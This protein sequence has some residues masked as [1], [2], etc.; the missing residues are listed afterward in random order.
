MDKISGVQSDTEYIMS[1]GKIIIG[2]EGTIVPM[3]HYDE[4]GE[5][6]GFD[7][8]YAKEVCS[9]IGIDPE[10]KVIDWDKKE[11]LLDNK[12]IDCVWS[13]LTITK[14]RM[15]KMSFS[16]VYLN[17]SQIVLIRKADA[18]KYTNLDS[19]LSAKFFIGAGS[20]GENII[21]SN[22]KLSSIQ[23]ETS[24][25]VQLMINNVKLGKCDAIIV[26]YTVAKTTIAKKEYSDL[27]IV[28]G[29]NLENEEYGVGFRLDSDMIY[30]VNNITMDMMTDG[31][32]DNIA[33]KYDLTELYEPAI[34]TD[35]KYIKGKRQLIIGIANNEPPMTY[36]SN[37]HELIGFDIDFAK[38]VS[39]NLGLNPL[40]KN[41]D[42]NNKEK[43]LK[44][45]KI[46]CIWSSL[47]V[48]EQ[49]RKNMKFSR[50]YMSNK[51]CIV[52]RKSD[53]T[54][55]KSWD[56]FPYSSV[57][58]TAGIDTTGE[59]A[60]HNNPYLSLAN[61]IPSPTMDESLDELQ[62]GNCDVA[63]IDYI[64]ATAS[65]KGNEYSDLMI[66]P[67]LDLANEFYAIGFRANSDMTELVNEAIKELIKDNT[68]L[69][70]AKKYE[71]TELY[72]SVE[73]QLEKSDSTYIMGNG[74]IIIGVKE[75]N[76]PFSYL[77]KGV[78]T[79]IDI[80]LSKLF[81]VLGID[82]K[83]KI[84]NDWSNKEENLNSKEI[85]CI[86]NG[87]MNVNERK[88]D[89]R[90]N[91]FTL[92]E[93]QAVIIDRS[94]GS[95]FPNLE[96]LSGS[97]IAAEKDST[98]VKA[99]KTNT[100][101]KKA[102]LTEVD[103]QNNMLDLL[104]KGTY[105]AVIMDY[106]NAKNSIKNY[107]NLI[108]LD[109][110]N[111]TDM[112]YAFSFR[113]GSDMVK[114][115]NSML[116]KL[117]SDGTIR[118]IINS[119]DYHV[120][121]TDLLDYSDLINVMGSGKII[122]GIHKNIPPMS[123]TNEKG[124]L[125]GFD[126]EFAKEVCSRL[127]I[128]P[129]FH[130]I[131]WEDMN[132]ELSSKNIDCVWSSLTVTDKR[133]E[134]MKFSRV[135]LNNRQIIIIHKSNAEVYKDVSSFSKRILTALNGSSGEQSI[136]HN[137]YLSS[138]KYILSNSIEEALNAIKRKSFDG[139]V[140]DY[141][142]ARSVVG[143]GD[144]ADLMI[145]SNVNLGD[146]E[147]AIGFRSGSDL[148]KK[149]N[150][151]I[152]DLDNEKW[153]DNIASKYELTDLLVNNK[154]SDSSYIMGNGK[155]IIGIEGNIVPMTYY[156]EYGELTGFDYEFAKEACSRIG[157][158]V[159]FRII[160]WEKKENELNNYS[161]DCV[162]SSL[163]ITE[164]RLKKMN[165]SYVY[166]TN[167]Q[168]VVI[169][170][171]DASKYTTLESL[172]S[173][174]FSVEAGAIGEDIIKSN[175]YISKASYEISNSVQQI[176]EDLKQEKCDA[177]IIDYT[178]AKSTIAKKEFKDL[179]IIDGINL[180]NEEYGVGFRFDSD[181]PNKVNSVIMDMMLDGTLENIAKKYD[182]TDLY[183]PIIKTDSIYLMEKK[184]LII[185]VVDNRPTMTYYNNTDELIGFDIDFAKAVTQKLGL[186]PIFKNI[187][188]NN[189][190]S[191]LKTRKVDCIWSAVSVTEQRRK[192]M[193]FSRVYM[194][195]KQCVV[196][197]KSDESKFKHLDD[198]AYTSVR[199]TAGIDTTG[200]EAIHNNPYLSLSRYI[201]SPTEEESL[202]ELK[203]GNCDAA[204]ID[205][206]MALPSIKSSEYSDLMIVPGLDLPNEFYAIGFRI[207]SDMT[208]KVNEVIKELIKDKTLLNLAKKYELTEL[209][210]SVK[211]Q[212]E[213]SDSTYIMG[214]GEIIIGVK[215]NNKP[216]S[217]LEKGVLTG[218]DIEFSKMFGVLGI[219]V[220]HKIIND[221]SNKNEKLKSKEIDCIWNGVMNASERSK[222]VRY[223][224]VVLNEKQVVIIDRSNGS[225]FP[226][227]ES[228]SGSKIAAEKDSAG[229]KVIKANDY[230]KKA[231]LT[232][233]DSQSNLVD[234]LKKGTYDAI[235]M[236]YIKAKKNIKY[237]EDVII[238]EIIDMIDTQYAF[239]FRQGSDMVK[240]FN[241][242]LM[243]LTMDGMI[244]DIIN[245]YDQQFSFAN[246]MDYSDLYNIIGNR[247]LVIGIHNNI[248]PLSYTNEKGELVGFDT[249][250][251]KEVCSRLGIEPE[252]YKINWE[253]MF[254]ELSSRNVDC[255]WSSLTVTDKRR[256][257]M[258]FSRVYL[259][260]KQ[261]VVIHK[262]NVGIYKD[263][264]TLSKAKIT[265][266]NGSS[267]EQA[268]GI[269][270]YLS[271]AK[272]ILSNTV[273]E[274]L[275]A[276]KEKGIDAFI[277]D[278]T[279]ARS[280][281]GK[282]DYVDLVIIDNVNLGNEEFA[283]GFRS[284]SDLTIKINEII[285][286]LIDE[287][288][289]DKIAEKYELT[290][291]LKRNEIDNDTIED[292]G[293][294][295]QNNGAASLKNI[296]IFGFVNIIAAIL[297][298][299]LLY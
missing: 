82:V 42:W 160:D 2:I 11:K 101:L 229:V 255:I 202:I 199:I 278:Y 111:V 66:I 55:F 171:K 221:W 192:N 216:F 280:V 168:I 139:F 266:L 133:R 156:N 253:D 297:A 177:I 254:N 94:N 147:F 122:I 190:E 27:M 299:V 93:K 99:I 207:N 32:L 9:R 282:G 169:K 29:I 87:I 246:I 248:P 23:Y 157:V 81:R 250:F 281:V 110:I 174:K 44:S 12:T 46:D 162:W 249:E 118:N 43:E 155:M 41:I 4:Y 105:D 241:P 277:I 134:N 233:V 115:V 146:E 24:D 291:L 56:D 273:E 172:K 113:Q 187:D 106:T 152:R 170:K 166:L 65:V 150:E 191:D 231:T 183:K 6:T 165:F 218:I 120:G 186:T 193:K 17:N 245:E 21:K 230:L 214:N 112:Q 85:D 7:Y 49:R 143:K 276:V 37:T 164:E 36:Y 72:E 163:T 203:K 284:G 102:T 262:S 16:Y 57:R 228:L 154:K 45:R 73:K 288:W 247:K 263:A 224:S 272:Y 226:N 188:W 131:N 200:E 100:Y 30:K 63:I 80:E 95:K 211:K 137:P 237:L 136:K 74:E 109:E 295:N 159:E 256:E 151:V 104:K 117:I 251:A 8:E 153:L 222:D 91:S 240:K 296:N 268:I 298:I 283:I 130:K 34:V 144:Y 19:L 3:V 135:Y 13:A 52:I 20:V 238:L 294:K 194:T 274:A 217:Y 70:L 234:L 223:N 264:T 293:L 167:K 47:T 176:F 83:H 124:E 60:I 225:K 35:K 97:K 1:N 195:N 103:S 265:A 58:I 185:G 79:G 53:E 275:N 116:M 77:E 86:W 179:M 67:G 88:N 215:E 108:I 121:F 18:S 158:D 51:Q 212:L 209:Y 26:D 107:E 123:Y 227:L 180:G 286:K 140:I 287:K 39:Q 59:E 125:V 197:R 259:N 132:N 285:I 239:S 213:K 50:V 76:K 198:F 25:S 90:Y 208:E 142:T 289:L 14:Q 196:I 270:P 148:T 210:E 84:I 98:S 38:A 64:M 173:A 267:G 269:N 114:T 279:T 22:K 220:K 149:I 128:E 182:L 126:T 201:P 244:N 206:T 48:T 10:F 96:S 252:F 129:E 271:S 89:I 243:K 54:K 78:L 189:K 40:F 205:Y 235:I 141:T 138:A 75:N 145:V 232:E 290:D 69:N 61:Y 204:V 258:K 68:L 184:E 119:Q 31:T 181:M 178:I 15:K 242:L 71:L 261:I 28:D 33:K 260:N 175:E 219:D 62:K 257:H 161:I 5:L 292:P 127:G 92:N 236:D